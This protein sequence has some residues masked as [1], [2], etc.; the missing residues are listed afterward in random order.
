MDLVIIEYGMTHKGKEAS[1]MTSRFTDL[2]IR[3][4]NAAFSFAIIFKLS[5]PGSP[6]PFRPQF[7]LLRTGKLI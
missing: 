7:L 3:E 6:Y 4:L 5:N 2:D 1:R